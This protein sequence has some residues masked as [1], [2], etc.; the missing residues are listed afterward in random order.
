MRKLLLAAVVASAGG[1]FLADPVPVAAAPSDPSAETNQPRR[2]R[3]QVRPRNRPT[4]PN[5]VRQC[6]AQLVQENRLSGT[7][8]VP[9]MHCWWE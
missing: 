1:I 9:R 3:V 2:T 5:S 7:V 6:R 8:V 4:G